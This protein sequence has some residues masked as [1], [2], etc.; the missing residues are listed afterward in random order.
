MQELWDKLSAYIG[1]LLIVVLMRRAT[2]QSR[3]SHQNC[4]LGCK[5]PPLSHPPEIPKC[6]CHA[7]PQLIP[8]SPMQSLVDCCVGEMSNWVEPSKS[9]TWLQNVTSIPPPKMPQNSNFPLLKMPILLELEPNMNGPQNLIGLIQETTA[10]TA[11]RHGA[12]ARPV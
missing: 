1:R 11:R 7:S 8:P 9:P 3:W 4:P 10:Y 6:S 2:R 12:F 5:M